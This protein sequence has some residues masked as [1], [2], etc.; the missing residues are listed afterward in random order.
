MVHDR[1][2]SYSLTFRLFLQVSLVPYLELQ[3]RAIVHLFIDHADLLK[4]K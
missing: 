2:L 1:Y 4:H 3:L